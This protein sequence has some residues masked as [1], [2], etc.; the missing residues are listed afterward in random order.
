[1]KWND[2]ERDIVYTD[3]K[4]LKKFNNKM[5]IIKTADSCL[6]KIIIIKIT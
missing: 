4:T 1:M 5:S 2:T 3:G 6:I